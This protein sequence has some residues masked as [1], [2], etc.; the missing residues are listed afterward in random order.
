M[1]R[2]VLER[3]KTRLLRGFLEVIRG[4]ARMPAAALATP[5]LRLGTGPPLVFLPGLASHYRPL[6][7]H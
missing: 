3:S 2:R 5:F 7:H 6:W 1:M 4:G